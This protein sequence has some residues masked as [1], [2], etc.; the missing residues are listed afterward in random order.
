[1]AFRITFPLVLC[2][3]FLGL[4]APKQAMGEGRAEPAIAQ[5]LEEGRLAEGEKAMAELI[6]GNPQ[7]QQARF[8]LGV[9]KFLR[10]L[11][12]LAQT[13]YKYG[14]LQHR[15]D[16]PLARF[17]LPRNENPQ[18]ISY[19]DARDMLDRFV[20]DLAAAEK[21]LAEVGVADVKLPLQFRRIRLDLNGDGEATA[22]ETLWRLFSAVMGRRATETSM[23]TRIA[24]DGGDVHWLRGYC[25]LLMSLG[26]IALAYDWKELFERTGHLYYPRVKSP[27]PFLRQE[28][29]R[30]VRRFDYQELVDIIAAIHLIN[31]PVKEAKRLT[32]ALHHL[33]AVVEQSRASWKLI[34]A[35]TDDDDEW[36]P[37]PR[38]VGVLPNVRVRKEMI[39]SWYAFLDEFEAIL[40]GKKLIPFWRGGPN[41]RLFK[42]AAHP[43]LG[44]NLRRVFTEPRRFDLV[45]WVQG[46]GAAPYLE[47]GPITDAAVWNRLQRVFRGE[48]VGFAIWFN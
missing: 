5:Y 1:M 14:L 11:E 45:L 10:A 21:A 26:E 31:F 2:L 18:E 39:N 47:K 6:A 40:K 15:L 28:Q 16:L 35:E 34:L 8:S 9:V 19:Q 17:P 7:D 22:D 29:K 46:T 36:I 41:G 30:D 44:V 3:T 48:F 37:N 12:R 38:Q 13:H 33:E 24:F 42:P 23:P 32:S 4:S 27:Y 43:E 25:H 20:V